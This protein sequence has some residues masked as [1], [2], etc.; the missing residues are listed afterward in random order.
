MKPFVV[1]LVV[2]SSLV[3]GVGYG[4]AFA[5]GGAPRWAPWCLA[6]GSN[7]VLMSL[8]AL[9]AMRRGRLAPALTVTYIGMFL[10]CAGA[11]SVALAMPANEGAAGPL[12]LGLPVRTAIV[13]YA[14]GVVPIAV[15]PFV[16]ALTF[17]RNTLSDDDLQRVRAAQQAMRERESGS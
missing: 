7:G 2:V 13:L 5:T 12:L 11:F 1:S 16:Y 9:G 6:I 10:L 3:V 17:D 14:V 4:S 15:L 8:M